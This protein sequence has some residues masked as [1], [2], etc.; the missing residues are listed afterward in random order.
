MTKDFRE[1]WGRLLGTVPCD[2][3]FA[4]WGELYTP[5]TIRHGIVKTAQK[6]LSI[7][8]RMTDDDKVRFASACMKASTAQAQGSGG[9]V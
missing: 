6:N 4:F 2:E 5:E 8:R 1:L 3:Q 9:D 7:G